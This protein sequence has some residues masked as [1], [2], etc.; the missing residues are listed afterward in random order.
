MIA[1]WYFGILCAFVV[2]VLAWAARQPLLPRWV[3]SQDCMPILWHTVR[4]PLSRERFLLWQHRYWLQYEHSELRATIAKP[5]KSNLFLR[6]II[7]HKRPE[8]KS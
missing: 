7:A 2:S 4:V 8:A 6:S 3:D 1:Y 5:Y